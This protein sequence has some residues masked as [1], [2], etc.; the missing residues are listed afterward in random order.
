MLTSTEIE[1]LNNKTAE[2]T[3]K[4]VKRYPVVTP[5]FRSNISSNSAN[6]TETESTTR[7]LLPSNE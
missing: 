5:V 1:D 4:Q 7:E 6:I 3:S 2:E